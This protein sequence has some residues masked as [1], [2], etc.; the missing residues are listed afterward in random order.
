MTRAASDDPDCRQAR[1]RKIDQIVEARRGPA[2]R[3]VA[4]RL[5]ADHAV[6]GVGRLVGG[7]ARQA[8][9]HQ[10]ERGRD[11]AVGE[12]FGEA[13]DGGARNTRFVERG[14]I[15]ADDARNRLPSGGKACLL[16]RDGN[17]GHVLIQAAASQQRARQRGL[18]DQRGDE[19]KRESD[20]LVDQERN[21]DDDEKDGRKREDTAH[22]GARGRQ[23]PLVPDLLGPGN[24]RTHP[25]DRMADAGHELVGIANER[26]DKSARKV[27]ANVMPSP[28]RSAASS[29]C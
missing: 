1:R 27:S 8:A 25:G 23:V 13:L 19:R 24:Q 12:V 20:D 4:L 22:P 29:G 14:R 7:A 15:A 10:P 11:D 21:R 5:V 2:E 17:I 9:N 28:R 6:G 26:F 18:Q 3:E 16:K